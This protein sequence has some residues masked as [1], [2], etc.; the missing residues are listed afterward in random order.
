MASGMVLDAATELDRADQNR[1]E[2]PNQAER[3]ESPAPSG[4]FPS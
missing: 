1:R 3:Q 4:L 2:E